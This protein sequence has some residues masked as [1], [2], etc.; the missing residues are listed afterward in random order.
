MYIDENCR[1]YANIN[2]DFPVDIHCSEHYKIGTVIEYHW[3][4]NFEILYFEKGKAIVYCNSHPVL[5]KPG[6][7]IIINSNDLHYCESL[8]SH[9]IYYVVEFDLSFINSNKVDLCQTKYMTPLVQNRILFRN[10]IEQ[11]DQLLANVRQLI[12]EYYGCEI[13]YELSIKGYIYHIMVLLLRD[14]VSQTISENEKDWQRKNLHR[15]Q[16]VLAY[17]D[18]H[19]NEKISLK[20]LAAMVNMSTHYFCRL[21]KNLTGNPPAEYLNHLRLNKAA[22]LLRDSDLNITEIAMAV[23]F[24]DSNYFSRLFKKYKRMPP[25]AVQ[26][27][28]LNL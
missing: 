4:E 28:S 23:G 24:N 27:Q 7:L 6:E 16:P 18:C 11:N 21:F 19:Y 9:L 3:H 2:Q 14:Y 10:Q 8:S 22:S 20:Q 1:G 5:V 25:S 26:K 13:G 12:K 17:M 15:L